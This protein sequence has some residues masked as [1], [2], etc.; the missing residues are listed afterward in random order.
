MS[1]VFISHFPE[2]SASGKVHLSALGLSLATPL[3]A[4]AR[5]PV[6]PSLSQKMTTMDGASLLTAQF[7]AVT[8][9]ERYSF[10][11]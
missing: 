7:P 2:G 11:P 9:A 3:L 6:H 5:I 1:Q 8:A 4:N 10:S